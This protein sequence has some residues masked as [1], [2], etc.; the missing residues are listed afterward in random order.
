MSMTNP[1]DLPMLLHCEEVAALLRTSPE[2]VYAMKARGQLPGVVVVGRRRFLVR[3][4]DL[5]RSINEGCVSS[6]RT[7][8]R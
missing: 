7:N 4:D 6:P 5:L 2:G 1:N 8:R 3:R